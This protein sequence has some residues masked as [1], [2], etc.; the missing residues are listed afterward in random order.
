MKAPAPPPTPDPYKL[1]NAQQLASISVAIS[2]MVLQNTDLDTEEFTTG[3]TEIGTYSI[4]DPQYDSTGTLTGT[5]TRNIPR[6]KSTFAL[7]PTMKALW[8]QEQEI[9][10][11]FNDFALAQTDDLTTRFATGFSISGLSAKGVAPTAP[12]FANTVSNYATEREA[13]RVAMLARLEYQHEIDRDSLLS[14]MTNQGL[15]AGMTAY[16][17][18]LYDFDKKITDARI[19]IELASID[20]ASKMIRDSITVLEFGNSVNM[21]TFQVL[22]D[23]ADFA[24]A[25]RE[26]NLQEL[27]AERGQVIN[28]LTALTHGG[29]ITMPQMRDTK[30]G[31]ISDTNLIGAVMG[32]AGMDMQKYQAAVGRQNAM[33]GGIAGIAGGLLSL[34]M[35]GGGSVGGNLFSG[36]MKQIGSS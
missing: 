30:G 5:T 12:T 16:D 13:T 21:R 29:H 22:R 35:A 23:L 15:A 20:A 3:F 36:A 25:M 28:E 10:S 9:K 14:R 19:Q 18:E 1:S 26:R 11:R 27:I 7:K 17:R 32:A 2:S 4:N 24:N 8:D 33:M 34:P 6:F 31:Q